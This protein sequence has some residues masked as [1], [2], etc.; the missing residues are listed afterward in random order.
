MSPINTLTPE[1][2]RRPLQTIFWNARSCIMMYFFLLKL[3][4]GLLARIRLAMN[5]PLAISGKDLLP[6]GLHEQ[7]LI[8]ICYSTCLAWATMS[9]LNTQCAFFEILINFVLNPSIASTVSCTSGGWSKLN[10]LGQRQNVR[11]FPDDIFKCILNV[12]ISIKISL[13]FVSKVRT[14]NIPALV[15]ITTWRL[16]G[17]KPLSEPMMVSL[18]SHIWVTRPQCVS[19]HCAPPPPPPP[20]LSPPQP[21]PPPLPT[22]PPPP[23]PGTAP[24]C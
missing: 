13:K 7:M 14:N 19:H 22:P 21:P 23:P 5:Q 9:L 12:W 6:A 3:H 17:D 18:L 24:T 4:R 20:L 16:P 11:H 1:Q 10:T 8:Q 15:K 2:N